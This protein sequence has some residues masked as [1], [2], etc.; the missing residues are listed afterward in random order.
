MAGG[1][2]QDALRARRYMS[3]PPSR[4][5]IGPRPEYARGVLPWSAGRLNTSIGAESG[6][7]EAT[8]E[9]GCDG[10]IVGACG[11]RHRKRAPSSAL[12]ALGS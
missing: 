4:D 6:S 8:R 2:G 11:A 5:E 12:S 10:V 1:Q 9:S 3:L 7:P